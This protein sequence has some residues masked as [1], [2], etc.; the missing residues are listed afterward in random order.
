MRD[1]R[2]RAHEIHDKQKDLY[3]IRKCK[4]VQ[5][6]YKHQLF[7]DESTPYRLSINAY[8]H[9]MSQIKLSYLK[10]ITK[11]N[12]GKHVSEVFNNIRKKFKQKSVIQ[13]MKDCLP[14]VHFRYSRGKYISSVHGYKA[15]N[16]THEVTEDGILVSLKNK[17]R[18]VR[19]DMKEKT[20]YYYQ[21]DIISYSWGN[22]ERSYPHFLGFIDICY[23]RK[24]WEKYF[25]SEGFIP[26]FKKCKNADT[27]KD[28]DAIGKFRIPYDILEEF[29]NKAEAIRIRFEQVQKIPY[30]KSLKKSLNVLKEEFIAQYGQVMYNTVEYKFCGIDDNKKYYW[31]T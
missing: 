9:K 11:N 4:Y 12:E 31:S 22:R 10:N 20:L 16:R 13:T 7:D 26:K 3:H 28:Y 2:I 23:R 15:Y 18:I 19:R 6:K 29:F 5:E 14:I 17:K 8:K 21:R 27:E 30:A 1:Y 25:K 24:A